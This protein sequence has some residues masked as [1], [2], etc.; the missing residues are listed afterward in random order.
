MKI[1]EIKETINYSYLEAGSFS[2]IYREK[3]LVDQ[4]TNRPG[5]C[6]KIFFRP[7]ADN[8]NKALESYKWGHDF[9]AY[10]KNSKPRLEQVNLREA[11][12]I[13]NLTARNNLAARVYEIALLKLNGQYYPVLILDDLGFFTESQKEE[14]DRI[15]DAIGELGNFYGFYF[16]FRDS[17]RTNI[18]N[19]KFLDFQGLKL[20]DEYR[21]RMI[22]RYMKSAV[23]GGNT[24]QPVPELNIKGYRESIDRINVI[25]A[26]VSF[27]GKKV[28]DIGT[29]GGYFA[30]YARARG[31]SRVTAYDLPSVADSA[32]EMSNYLG[33][34]DIDYYGRELR[35]GE[36]VKF[37]FE[38]DIIFYLSMYRYLAYA[39]FLKRA[40]IV[41]YEH[42]GDVPPEVAINEFKKDFKE[43][44]DLGVTGKTDDRHTYIFKK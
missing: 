28:I 34:Y 40:N 16:T 33:F 39:P 31:A 6:L 29:S 7:L 38:P 15:M 27:K 1:I 21:D 37:D 44:I 30:R 32:F 12:I 22:E 20:V 13:E 41:I 36:D 8:S 9:R 2:F 25:A 3:W 23:W 24:Y 11:V 14:F 10:D 26:N 5:T 43:I 18:V 19:K 4:F 35:P 17:W 42:N